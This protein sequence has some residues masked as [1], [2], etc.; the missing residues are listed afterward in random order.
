[1]EEMN[2]LIKEN[3]ELRARLDS[4][5]K[6]LE[7]YKNTFYDLI[8]QIKEIGV[9]LEHSHEINVKEH[10]FLKAAVDNLPFEVGAPGDEENSI[11]FY[12]NI[13]DAETTIQK[14]IDER[15][16]IARFGDGEFAIICGHERQKFQKL[17]ANLA[18]RLKQVLQ[19]DMENLLIGIAD[20]YGNLEKYTNFAADGIRTYMQ[21]DIRREHMQLLSREKQYYDAYMSRPYVMYQDKFTDAP[22]KRFNHLKEIWNDRDVIMI[23]GAQTRLGVGND[24]FDN[25]RS[26][27]RILAPAT[28]SYDRYDEILEAALRYGKEND[29]FLIAT[30]P[31]AG[32]FVYDLMMKGLQAVDIG[33]VDIEYEWFLRGTGDRTP[34]ENKYTNEVIGQEEAEDIHD[35]VYES[36]IIEQFP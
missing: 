5:E 13:M 20:N 9:A 19:S 6:T 8:Q 27:R 29:L 3:E 31:S 17:D 16:S 35:P 28:S 10:A 32:V 14:I 12:P 36:Q 15:K 7:V 1:M 22:R 4:V 2:R 34:I 30:G 18:V 24:L 23:E 33:H 21:P 25:C 26:I 11:F